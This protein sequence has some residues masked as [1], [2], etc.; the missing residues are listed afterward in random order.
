MTTQQLT[1][2]LGQAQRNL[3]EALGVPALTSPVIDGNNAVF[4]AR[5]LD[6]A[7]VA[8]E[9]AKHSKVRIVYLYA[10]TLT[11]SASPAVSLGKNIGWQ[12]IARRVEVSSGAALSMHNDS[13]LVLYTG[14]IVNDAHP[15]ALHVRIPKSGGG[16]QDRYPALDGSPGIRLEVS[17]DE[18]TRTPLT[19]VPMPHN[20]EP[21]QLAR[22]TTLLF[23]VATQL[24]ASNRDQAVA[25]LR[26]VARLSAQSVHLREVFAQASSLLLLHDN[27]RV[28]G[29][30]VPYLNR[31]VYGDLV[32]TYKDVV[33]AYEDAYVILRTKTTGQQERVRAAELLRDNLK[34]THTFH[35]QLAQ[36]AKANTDAAAASLTQAQ[37]NLNSHQKDVE[38]AK[39]TFEKN[40]EAYKKKMITAAVVDGCLALLSLGLAAA[41]G[42]MGA[43]A[44]TKQ[45]DALIKMVDLAK[46][47][48]EA[49]G[50]IKKAVD[51]LQAALKL[52]DRLRK[53][54]EK[55]SKDAGDL[56]KL[57]AKEIDR[58]LKEIADS[59]S[60][61][62]IAEWEN[63]QVIVRAMF[64]HFP[65][66]AEYQAA[67]EG[68]S[69][70]GRAFITA[71]TGYLQA[72]QQ[73]VRATLQAQ[74]T[75][76]ALTR[77]Q[78]HIEELKKGASLSDAA[79]QVF[80][81]GYLDQKRWLFIALENYGRAFRYWALAEPAVVP[82]MAGD[83]AYI[84]KQIGQIAQEYTDALGKFYPPP[85]VMT[86]RFPLTTGL[87]GLKTN[88]GVLELAITPGHEEFEDLERVRLK[89]IRVYLEGAKP[90]PGKSIKISIHNSG[91]YQDCFKGA[92]FRFVSRPVKRAFEYK[93]GEKKP[94]IDGTIE[95]EFGKVLMQPTPFTQWRFTV[96]AKNNPGLDLSK[97]TAVRLEM[98]GSAISA[99]AQSSASAK[100]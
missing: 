93:Q 45:I 98:I 9:L 57:S 30:Y 76:R 95:E 43:F 27:D 14:T 41:S 85:Q 36:Q 40:M 39:T 18:L 5:D 55:M 72:S 97:V 78:S 26:W 7:T 19:T 99:G 92:D 46:N 29:R 64:G 66:G 90:A 6:T 24:W 69:V 60:V 48:V 21:V 53:L 44:A 63:F 28:H 84:T 81:Q 88:K 83:A 11:V 58:L 59:G 10:D 49:A 62:A 79:A 51:D 35:E 34:D 70:Y 25:L 12:V 74:L 23:Q 22:S 4:H 75:S 87:D 65:Q 3:P 37:E 33:K 2:S 86:K 100:A 15:G 56:S 17:G 91:S 13:Q 1:V 31:E 89:T 42:A 67:L 61:N 32:K 94:V 71:Q 38:K 8:K 16:E 52:L 77:A 73:Q 54:E 80:Y 50:K 47:T 96:S 82:T 68:M 20:G